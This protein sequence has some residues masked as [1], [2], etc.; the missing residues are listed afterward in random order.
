MARGTTTVLLPPKDSK[1][2]TTWEPGTIWDKVEWPI[3]ERQ[4]IA[5]YRVSDNEPRAEAKF[6][7]GTLPR[8]TLLKAYGQKHTD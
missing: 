2:A 7:R 4:P 3:L 8:A 1:P 5:V 6:T